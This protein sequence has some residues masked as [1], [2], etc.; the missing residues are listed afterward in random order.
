MGL[1]LIF[2]LLI[3]LM[4]STYGWMSNY[5]SKM[6]RITK[7][8]SLKMLKFLVFVGRSIVRGKKGKG[9]CTNVAAFI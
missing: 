9:F 2:A 1:Y 3:S 7:I 4:V 6:V 5:N 8:V